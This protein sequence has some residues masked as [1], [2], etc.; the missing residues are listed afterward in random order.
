V[1]NLFISGEREG[2]RLFGAQAVITVAQVATV[3][4][5]KDLNKLKVPDGAGADIAFAAIGTFGGPTGFGISTIYFLG[6]AADWW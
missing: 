6:E 2:N 5:N 1:A 4:I 3:F